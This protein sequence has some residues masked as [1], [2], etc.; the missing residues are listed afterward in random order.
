MGR[1]DTRFLRTGLARPVEPRVAGIEQD[2]SSVFSAP[3]MRTTGRQFCATLPRRGRGSCHCTFGQKGLITSSTNCL[4]SYG[5]GVVAIA[6]PAPRILFLP[7][8]HAVSPRRIDGLPLGGILAVFAVARENGVL[9]V[10]F[11]PRKAF[12]REWTGL[13]AMPTHSLA[14]RR[15]VLRDKQS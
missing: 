12:R 1:L 5:C 10:G 3:G 7:K 14:T 9:A 11:E 4:H 2:G 15:I 8:Q 13:E 6:A